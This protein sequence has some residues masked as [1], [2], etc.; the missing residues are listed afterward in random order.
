MFIFHNTGSISSAAS[1]GICVLDDPVAK[2]LH[3]AS[4]RI[5]ATDQFSTAEGRS[6]APSEQNGLNLSQQQAVQRGAPPDGRWSESAEGSQGSN[7]LLDLEEALDYKLSVVL[8]LDPCAG[9]CVLAPLYAVPNLL[10]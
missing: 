10:S 4:I 9:A 7:Q 5:G 6:D 8:V 2:A 3:R 1:P